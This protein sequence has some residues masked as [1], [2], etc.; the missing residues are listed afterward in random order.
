MAG[1]PPEVSE[2]GGR[3]QTRSAETTEIIGGRLDIFVRGGGSLTHGGAEDGMHD[4][5]R[6]LGP[7]FRPQARWWL[8]FALLLPTCGPA[9][10]SQS[11]Q[12]NSRTVLDMP[13]DATAIVDRL[14]ESYWNCRTY[15]DQGT[16]TLTYGLPGKQR[17]L[18][19][20]F[21]TVYRNPRLRFAFGQGPGIPVDSPDAPEWCAWA[22]SHA[23][24]PLPDLPAQ[25]GLAIRQFLSFDTL[26][27]VPALLGAD[28]AGPGW[29]GLCDSFQ[30]VG[31]ETIGGTPCLVV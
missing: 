19:W 6:M 17:T 22:S 3:W 21:S 30:H 29:W 26:G 27:T 23:D 5:S 4:Q 16:L 24:L 2:P 11:A 8:G 13:A 10:S 7:S 1:H 14:H 18:Q 20:S 28:E 15:R 9:E 12:G 25:D 31:Y